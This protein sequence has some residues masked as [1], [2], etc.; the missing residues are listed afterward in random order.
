MELGTA[1]TVAVGGYL[2]GSISFARLVVRLFGPQKEMQQIDVEVPDSEATF[3][4]G[5]VSA[6][7]VNLQLGPRFGCLTSILDIAK[8]AVPALALR[9]WQPEMPYYLIFAGLGTVGHNWPVYHRFRG[10]RGMSTIIGGMLVVDW[11]GILV[12]TAVSMGVG[13]LMRSFYI[14]NRLTILLMVPWLWFR[15]RDWRL[16]A[17]AVF[18][19]V[20]NWIA[21]IP[22]AREMVRLRRAG[23]LKDF[24]E[25]KQVRVAG[26]GGEQL[27]ERATFYG[28]LAKLLSK[29]GEEE[30]EPVG[31]A[32]EAG[33]SG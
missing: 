20:I 10:G 6:T 11:L 30:A 17:Y 1:V 33:R 18:V 22:E 4:S 12:T 24:L 29:D 7:T 13:L 15:H 9:L 2:I 23:K 14:A 3:R 5:A 26:S 16:V 19:N 21:V 27:G 8:V 25:A 31:S 32:S 28:M